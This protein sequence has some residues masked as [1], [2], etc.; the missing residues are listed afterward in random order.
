MKTNPIIKTKILI[1]G[2]IGLFAVSLLAATSAEARPGP[3]HLHQPSVPTSVSILS[4]SAKRLQSSVESDTRSFF[5]GKISPAAFQL[6]QV[7]KEFNYSVQSLQTAVLKREPQRRIDQLL[8]DVQSKWNRVDR[9]S[10]DVKLSKGTNMQITQV[11][12][13]LNT[14]IRNKGQLYG[15][16]PG[17]QHGHHNDRPAPKGKR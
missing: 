16:R 10:K 9:A 6:R 12:G 8:H 17:P 4:N 1:R 3:D 14:V 13:Q 2:A 15:F 11:R 7:A 5:K